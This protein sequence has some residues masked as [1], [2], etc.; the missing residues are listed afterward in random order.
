MISF[1][2]DR[3]EWQTGVSEMWWHGGIWWQAGAL[4]PQ[5]V[6][7]IGLGPPSW[8]LEQSGLA[9]CPT[10]ASG[11]STQLTH[12]TVWPVTAAEGAP[13]L[14]GSWLGNPQVSQYAWVFAGKASTPAPE[15]ES[16]EHTTGSTLQSWSLSQTFCPHFHMLPWPTCFSQPLLCSCR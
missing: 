8:R 14:P 11:F 5:V 12:S 3:Q 1:A 10:V 15:P 7:S 16:W 2:L 4:H 9:C 13:T 6:P